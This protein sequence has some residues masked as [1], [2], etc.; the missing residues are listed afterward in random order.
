MATDGLGGI[1]G[2]KH[3]EAADAPC[4]LVATHMDE[5]VFM[6]RNQSGWY[7]PVWLKIGGWSPG[8]RQPITQTLYS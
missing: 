3:S 6:V 2:I 7:L 5:M 8:G 1:F 4:V